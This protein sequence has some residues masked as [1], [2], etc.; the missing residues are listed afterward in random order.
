MVGTVVDQRSNKFSLWPFSLGV[1]FLRQTVPSTFVRDRDFCK[2][3]LL[4]SLVEVYDELCGH[5]LACD[6]TRD[7]SRHEPSSRRLGFGQKLA[8]PSA[9]AQRA[10]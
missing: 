2:I 8:A 10:K 5:L 4:D 9:G 3:I 7:I 6:D 1:V